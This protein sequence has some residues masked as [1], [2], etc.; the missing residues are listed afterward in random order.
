MLISWQGK[1]T[2]IKSVIRT[3]WHSDGGGH[4]SQQNVDRELG[5]QHFDWD[6]RFKF[7]EDSDLANTWIGIWTKDWEWRMRPETEIGALVGFG[8]VLVRWLEVTLP[9]YTSFSSLIAHFSAT[10]H[11]V[12]PCHLTE[13][14]FQLSSKHGRVEPSMPWNS[15]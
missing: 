2:E 5:E 1:L 9:L 8:S 14:G 12:E 3:N 6:W 7:I 13:W 10:L 15:V 11:P 4:N